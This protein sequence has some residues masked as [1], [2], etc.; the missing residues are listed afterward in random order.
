MALQ[1]IS[2]NIM[3]SFL[4]GGHQSSGALLD[5]TE[6]T[7]TNADHFQNGIGNDDAIYHSSTISDI[8]GS[9][10]ANA[11]DDINNYA[12]DKNR[13]SI[14]ISSANS[15]GDD[16]FMKFINDHVRSIGGVDFSGADKDLNYYHSN[17][18]NNTLYVGVKSGEPADLAAKKAV[19]SEGLK[20]RRTVLIIPSDNLDD[21]DISGSNVTLLTVYQELKKKFLDSGDAGLTS[22]DYESEKK[23]RNLVAGKFFENAS[24]RTLGNKNGLA[25]LTDESKVKDD[26]ADKNKELSLAIF[27]CLVDDYFRKA[28]NDLREFKT[29]ADIA[30]PSTI[31]VPNVHTNFDDN[32][33]NDAYIHTDYWV[34][35]MGKYRI[36]DHD[37]A[38]D[39]NDKYRSLRPGDR[40]YIERF[41]KMVYSANG[42]MS[43]NAASDQ[44]DLYKND[45]SAMD[46]TYESVVRGYFADNADTLVLKYLNPSFDMS[47][48]TGLDIKFRSMV[49]EDR[50]TYQSESYSNDQGG[51]NASVNNDLI[52]D[53]SAGAYDDTPTDPP[54]KKYMLASSYSRIGCLENMFCR[55]DNFNRGDDNGNL[56]NKYVLADAAGVF[57]G[58]LDISG[59]TGT[60]EDNLIMVTGGDKGNGLLHLVG[61]GY[62][63]LLS[64]STSDGVNLVNNNKIDANSG[65]TIDDEINDN[66][67]FFI[68][69][70]MGLNLTSEN[71]LCES[72]FNNTASKVIDIS[73]AFVNQDGTIYTAESGGAPGSV[74][75]APY[76]ANFNDGGDYASSNTNHHFSVPRGDHFEQVNTNTLLFRQNMMLSVTFNSKPNLP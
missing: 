8:S 66:I 24:I 39:A 55:L 70:N 67:T 15:S 43:A 50:Q 64:G 32:G 2:T 68:R 37:N 62:Y 28:Y 4:E 65:I 58:T 27:N 52:V 17:A 6:E 46:D 45:N 48:G 44:A 19:I 73:A 26:L 13:F 36:K 14:P 16:Q 9:A 56:H 47:D 29:Q 40:N 3:L 23:I 22:F 49:R 69:T 35:D 5:F 75:A 33:A 51:S 11:R 42:E 54:N 18:S 71:N 38:D 59:S 60:P 41:L 10:A 74:N 34:S 63:G 72:L 30:T 25:S 61:F 76:L 53:S 57:S 21:N 1:G 12:L 31:A 20:K 7:G